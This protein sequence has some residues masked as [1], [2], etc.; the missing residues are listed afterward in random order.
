M[1]SLPT[2]S[3]PVRLCAA[4]SL[5]GCPAGLRVVERLPSGNRHDDDHGADGNDEQAVEQ[6]TSHDTTVTANRPD[7]SRSAWASAVNPA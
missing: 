7:R 3:S 4:V 1:L 6:A 2:Y 5:A